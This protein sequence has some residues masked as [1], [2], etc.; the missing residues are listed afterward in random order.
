MRLDRS[1]FERDA[2]AVAKDLLGCFFVQN[3]KSNQIVGR[4]VETEAYGDATDLASH[5]R[6]GPTPRSQIMFGPAG[7]LYVYKIYGIFSLA[8]IVCGKTGEASAALIRAAEIVAGEVIA[9]R[10]LAQSKFVKLNEQPATGPGKFSLALGI[11]TGHNGTDLAA[12]PHLYLTRSPAG[13]EFKI[14]TTTRIGVDYAKDSKDL[15]WRFY[16]KDSPFVSKR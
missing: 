16:I 11:D 2:V 8:N 3:L 13:T 9:R 15:P 12:S 4:I 14:A 7:V 10:N 6:F 1:F 5:A